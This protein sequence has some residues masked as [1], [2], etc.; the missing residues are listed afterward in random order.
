MSTAY[1]L[2]DFP[3]TPP[4][5]VTRMD[6]HAE[7]DS[8]TITPRN[9]PANN[10]R[11]QISPSNRLDTEVLPDSTTTTGQTPLAVQNSP[12][13]HQNNLDTSTQSPESDVEFVRRK[14]LEG[15]S[16]NLSNN[17]DSSGNGCRPFSVPEARPS[18]LIP[19]SH[20]LNAA[21]L[22]PPQTI[23]GRSQSVCPF[24][25]DDMVMVE[26]L[27]AAPWRGVVRWIGELPE[28]LGQTVAGIEMVYA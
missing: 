21:T 26:R 25:L 12:N 1:P 20:Q 23:P 8:T 4:R 19:V 22:T 9:S 24:E 10:S 16:S 11:L 27:D 6:P 15:L 5:L 17:S 18:S 13:V 2:S 3:P 14:R 28:T 7:P